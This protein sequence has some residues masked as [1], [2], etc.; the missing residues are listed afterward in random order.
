MLFF[1]TVMALTAMGF[2][3]AMKIEQYYI[4]HHRSRRHLR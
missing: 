3:V 4:V 1:A 2:Y